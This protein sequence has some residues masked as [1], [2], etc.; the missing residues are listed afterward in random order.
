MI[1]FQLPE[2]SLPAIVS[3]SPHATLSYNR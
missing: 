2:K 3:L 1:F